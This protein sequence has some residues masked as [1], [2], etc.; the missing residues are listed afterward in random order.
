MWTK[1]LALLGL[2]LGAAVMGSA[3]VAET[4][5]E[6]LDLDTSL[7]VTA[8]DE[9]ADL[10]AAEDELSDQDFARRPR[11][12][13][14]AGLRCPG[15]MRCIDLPTDDCDPDR[16][17]AD[18]IG[19]CVGGNPR[20]LGCANPLRRYVSR[21]PNACAAILFRCEAGTTMFF[22]RC[23]CG[24]MNQPGRGE[25]DAQPE[26]CGNAICDRGEYCCNESCSI[27]API[28]GVC[29]QEFCG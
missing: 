29:T 25:A 26:R 16:G 19:V 24:C 12:G 17:G 4:T 21:D 5:D 10:G 6:T 9:E 20:R 8:A 13:G 15:N 1:G 2:S 28:G 22:D 27:C 11:C 23:G 7:P 18:C 14:F 3:C